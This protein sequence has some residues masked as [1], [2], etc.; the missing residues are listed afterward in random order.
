[1]TEN[2]SYLD[3][4]AKCEFHNIAQRTTHNGIYDLLWELF[5]YFQLLRFALY[6]RT[7]KHC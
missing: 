3:M 7:Y 6:D 5:L 1:M 4:S 2:D